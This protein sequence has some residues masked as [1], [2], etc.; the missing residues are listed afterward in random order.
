MGH[1]FRFIESESHYFIADELKMYTSNRE[2]I[3]ELG[4]PI[5][6][7]RGQ[8]WILCFF[9]SQ[10]LGFIGYNSSKILY[11]YV[12]KEYRKKG[13]FNEMYSCLPIQNWEVVASNMILPIFLKKGFTVIKNYKTC[14]KLRLVI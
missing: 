12:K 1:I 13:V 3:K 11:V 5:F 8:R 14:H 9:E 4:E 7:E 2:V 10:C 6:I